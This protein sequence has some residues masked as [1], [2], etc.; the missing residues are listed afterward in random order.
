MVDLLQERSMKDETRYTKAKGTTSVSRVGKPLITK[1]KK[2]LQ[3]TR[4]KALIKN[5]SFFSLIEKLSEDLYGP[6]HLRAYK[7]EMSDP[8]PKGLILEKSERPIK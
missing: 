7:N 5:F 8:K 6:P 3:W 2:M 4:L 1:V